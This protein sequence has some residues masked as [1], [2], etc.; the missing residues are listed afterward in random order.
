MVAERTNAAENRR[1]QNIRRMAYHDFAEPNARAHIVYTQ[2]YARFSGSARPMPNSNTY[3][4]KHATLE[5]P[6]RIR[7]KRMSDVRAGVALYLSGLGSKIPLFV[8]KLLLSMSS[9]YPEQTHKLHTTTLS[10][11]RRN[12]FISP[13]MAC[14]FACVCTCHAK[15]KALLSLI[16]TDISIGFCVAL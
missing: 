4:Y 7:A 3:P 6:L 13:S 8:V 14:A 16:A 11:F 5:R 15:L 1:L 10:S 2:L 12:E 9:N